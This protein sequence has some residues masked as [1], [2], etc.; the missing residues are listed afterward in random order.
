MKR[1]LTVLTL[2]LASVTWGTCF[3]KGVAGGHSSPKAIAADKVN[4][5]KARTAAS[6]KRKAQGDT[7]AQRQAAKQNLI[8]A[9]SAKKA[10]KAGL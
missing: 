2:A 10:R 8:T 6:A 4:L 1:T 9:R 3:A 7:I 5:G